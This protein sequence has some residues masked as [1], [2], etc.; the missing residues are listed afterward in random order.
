MSEW[1]LSL[2]SAS[3]PSLADY[4]SVKLTSEGKLERLT[5]AQPGHRSF[6]LLLY[7]RSLISCACTLVVERSAQ[8][9]FSIGCTVIINHPQSVSWCIIVIDHQPLS[10]YHHQVIVPIIII[11]VIEPSLLVLLFCSVRS[12]YLR[13]EDIALFLHLNSYTPYRRATSTLRLD[14]PH[15]PPQL[16]SQPPPK[17]PLP[18]PL[19]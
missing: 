8:G 16:T 15:L 19:P 5:Q 1:R 17:P 6:W 3:F 12:S 9:I 14:L 4:P 18:R 13:L 10:I 7:S 2:A 11:I